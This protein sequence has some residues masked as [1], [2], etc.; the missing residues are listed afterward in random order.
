M[1]II[2]YQNMYVSNLES[3]FLKFAISKQKAMKF[4]SLEKF[5]ELYKE[6]YNDEIN[7]SDITAIEIE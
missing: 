6:K 1:T 2:K 5:K 3:N 4:E 7:L